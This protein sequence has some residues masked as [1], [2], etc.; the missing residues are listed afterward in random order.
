MESKTKPPMTN[1]LAQLIVVIALL[2]VKLAMSPLLVPDVDPGK[3]PGPLLQL[4]VVP[5]EIQLLLK[6][7]A[8][9]VALAALAESVVAKVKSRAGKTA[10]E[11]NSER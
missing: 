3:V 2:L 4:F 6:G 7:D 9:Q 1:A 11:R 5:G 10:T 8:S